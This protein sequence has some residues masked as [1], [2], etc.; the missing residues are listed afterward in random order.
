MI[1]GKGIVK[2][3]LYGVGIIYFLGGIY[4]IYFLYVLMCFLLFIVV[5]LGGMIG[6]VIY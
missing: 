2:V 3:M 4:E 1:F 6:V 5:I